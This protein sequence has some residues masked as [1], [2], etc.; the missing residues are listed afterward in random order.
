MKY[1]IVNYIYNNEKLKFWNKVYVGFGVVFVYIF[2][3]I[4]KK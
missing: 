3:Y 1:I 2:L 4:Y